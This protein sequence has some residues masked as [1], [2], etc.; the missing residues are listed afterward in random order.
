MTKILTIAQVAALTFAGTV[1]AQTSGEK[2]ANPPIQEEQTILEQRPLRS[3]EE[4]QDK[5]RPHPQPSTSRAEGTAADST[6]PGETETRGEVGMGTGVNPAPSTSPVEGTAAD[7][8]P[9]GET[10]T[11]V[12]REK[13]QSGQESSHESPTRSAQK[14]EQKERAQ[15]VSTAKPHPLPSTSRAE[16]TAA[17]RTVPGAT[18]TRGQPGL[19]TGVNPAPSTSPAEGTAADSTPPG[20]TPTGVFREREEE[21]PHEEP[22]PRR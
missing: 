20:E 3:G 11:N 8:T 18:P 9:P 17:D 19:G 2:H 6:P 7:A 14:A 21:A 12:F 10:P 5:A 16:G 4:A 13:S 22:Q 15:D 1:A